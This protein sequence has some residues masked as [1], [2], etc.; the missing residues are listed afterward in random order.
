MLNYTV[1]GNFRTDDM[2]TIVNSNNDIL[3]IIG[4]FRTD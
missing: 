1:S 4:L 2:T 3:A